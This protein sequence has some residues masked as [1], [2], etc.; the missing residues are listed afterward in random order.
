M[1]NKGFSSSNRYELLSNFDTNKETA[2][3]QKV[4]GKNLTDEQ[5]SF[6]NKENVIV[7]KV[8]LKIKKLRSWER[9]MKTRKWL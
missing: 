9:S 5:S 1:A 8:D 7:I 4:K 3:Q 6:S 2:N